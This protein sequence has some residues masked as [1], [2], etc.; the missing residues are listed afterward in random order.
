MANWRLFL[1]FWPGST[2]RV[3]AFA[4]YTWRIE[5]PG[6]SKSK[7]GQELATKTATRKATRK[8]SH[9]KEGICK[10]GRGTGREPGRHLDWEMRQP[11]RGGGVWALMR[12]KRAAVDDRVS[13]RNKD[14][15]GLILANSVH[16]F[17]QQNILNNHCMS[18]IVH[19]KYNRKQ[20]RT[21][22]PAFMA[23]TAKL[24]R[25]SFQKIPV[26]DQGQ[27]VNE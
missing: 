1:Y 24:R 22:V 7:V 9:W 5:F 10:W 25:G 26:N 17:V 6:G 19:C 3:L 8:Q 18:R 11:Y 4:S 14:V 27:L 20:Y 15:H 2:I 23:P 12:V 13:R 16:S 21:T